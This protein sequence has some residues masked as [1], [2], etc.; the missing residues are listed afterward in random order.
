MKIIIF[1]LKIRNLRNSTNSLTSCLLSL[2]I[3]AT[4]LMFLNIYK[5]EHVKVVCVQCTGVTNIYQH[6]TSRPKPRMYIE[7]M[8]IIFFKLIPANTIVE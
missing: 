5:R 8:F 7:P 1:N 6:S 3:S 2:T 4:N